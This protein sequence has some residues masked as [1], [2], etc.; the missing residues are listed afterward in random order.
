MYDLETSSNEV[1]PTLQLELSSQIKENSFS[2]NSNLELDIV[3]KT[4][5]SNVSEVETDIKDKT[6]KSNYDLNILIPM[7]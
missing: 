5:D 2:N 3:N 4:F 7:S 1:Y 6:E